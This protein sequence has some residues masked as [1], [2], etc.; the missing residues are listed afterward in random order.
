MKSLRAVFLTDD[1]LRLFTGARCE[2]L[3][4]PLS[5]AVA[6]TVW[7][8]TESVVVEKEAPVQIGP[9]RSEVQLSPADRSPCSA[10]LAVPPKVMFA[11]WAKL[12]PF[13]GA[14]IPTVGAVLIAPTA[15]KVT[16]SPLSNSTE[17]VKSL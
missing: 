2:S 4:A 3:R 13:A 1:R 9:S 10:S 17:M 12:A 6:V 8:P 16:V 11:P 14:V 5:V 7:T 15:G